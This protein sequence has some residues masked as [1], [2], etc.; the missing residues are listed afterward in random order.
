MEADRSTPTTARAGLCTGRIHC[1]AAERVLREPDIG[2]PGADLPAGEKAVLA[3]IAQ[4]PNG[5]RREQLAVLTGYKRS[6]RD[7]YIARLRERDLVVLMNDGRIAANSEG[8][9]ALGSNYEPPLRGAALRDR[10]LATLPEG[11]SNVLAIVME[12]YPA[13]VSRDAISGATGYKRSTRD[14][15]IARLRA[16]ELIAADAAGIR[17]AETLFDEAA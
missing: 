1:L 6:T 15:Y 12:H 13:V 8:I 7:A 5:L 14:A 2:R 16:R 9:E 10:M 11:E 17:A 3:A 4:Y